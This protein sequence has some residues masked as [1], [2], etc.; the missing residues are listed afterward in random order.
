[1]FLTLNH[2]DLKR[3]FMDKYVRQQASIIVARKGLHG[4]ENTL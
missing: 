2:R 3:I 1:M 4:G